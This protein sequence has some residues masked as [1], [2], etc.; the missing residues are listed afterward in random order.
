MEWKPKSVRA[1]KSDLLDRQ[2]AWPIVAPSF[3]QTAVR[4]EGKGEAV[5]GKA[6]A[7]LPSEVQIADLV[8]TNSWRQGRKL[9]KDRSCRLQSTVQPPIFTFVRIGRVGW[10]SASSARRGYQDQEYVVNRLTNLLGSAGNAVRQRQK[11]T[12]GHLGKADGVPRNHDFSI[13]LV[14]GGAVVAWAPGAM[15][16]SSTA[17]RLK[18]GTRIDGATEI[19]S[20]ARNAR[21]RWVRLGSEWL[22]VDSCWGRGPFSA[23]VQRLGRCY[24][25]RTTPVTTL[26]QT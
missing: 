26:R 9:R 5:R 19:S 18:L 23:P 24:A 2:G 1:K 8:F 3:V 11:W 16:H 21:A 20:S 15:A 4:E 7:T 12:V 25:W 6:P 14:D 13:G 10:H 22:P 17:F